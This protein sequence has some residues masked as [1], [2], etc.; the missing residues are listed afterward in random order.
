MLLD[1]AVAGMIV[2]VLHHLEITLMRFGKLIVIGVLAG[3]VGLT[4]Y[5][6][7]YL[8]GWI[9]DILSSEKEIEKVS[10]LHMVIFHHQD[11]F[12]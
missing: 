4:K 3:I 10:T 1:V 8:G 9:V 12:F 7:L 11:F 5:A 6:Y 2:S